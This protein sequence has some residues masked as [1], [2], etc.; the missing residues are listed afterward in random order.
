MEGTTQ[1]FNRKLLMSS[2]QAFQLQRVQHKM[3]IHV[4]VVT[5]AVLWGKN[6][7][8]HKPTTT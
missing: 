5:A 4:T 2:Q 7:T 8:H 6:V 1:V 3:L